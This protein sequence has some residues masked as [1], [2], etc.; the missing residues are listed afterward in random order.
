ML[1]IFDGISF[2]YTRNPNPMK[3]EIHYSV[4]MPSATSV[5][6]EEA[7]MYKEKY[8]PSQR[9]GGVRVASVN[10]YFSYHSIFLY[11]T[12]KIMKINK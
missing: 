8:P 10:M 3:D 4:P 12:T 2:S 5:A 7:N 11:L 6:G 1:C 9:K